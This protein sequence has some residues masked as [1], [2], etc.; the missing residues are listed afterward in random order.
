MITSSMPRLP[1][2]EGQLVLIEV[3]LAPEETPSA[4]SLK[5]CGNPSCLLRETEVFVFVDR[6]P[7]S[8]MRRLQLAKAREHRDSARER[9]H[10][11]QEAALASIRR[12]WNRLDGL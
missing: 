5:G 3:H 9:Q 11:Q 2:A 1:V 8:H 7:A 12:A 4:D 6:S 10:A